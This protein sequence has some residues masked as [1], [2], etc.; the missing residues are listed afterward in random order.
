MLTLPATRAAIAALIPHQ[1]AMC[2]LEQV[3]R[4][5]AEG[6]GC[7]SATHREETNPLRRGGMLPAV[8]G[9][10]Y[11]AQAMALHGALSDD[12]AQPLGFLSALRD[13]RLLAA[14]LDDVEG[15]L[16]IEA[17]AEARES[18]GMIYAF[19]VSGGGRLLLEGRAVIVLTGGLP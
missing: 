12:A 7:T 17:R 11:A 14:R 4:V 10:E 3:E 19:S 13:L 6:I 1:G 5:D 15:A 2:L 9:V 16:A 18:R 8:A